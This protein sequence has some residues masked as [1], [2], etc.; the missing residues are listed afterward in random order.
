M[1][2]PRVRAHL[3]S[4][5]RQDRR[6]AL[7]TPVLYRATRCMALRMYEKA[8]TSNPDGLTMARLCGETVRTL[9][10]LGMTKAVRDMT[11]GSWPFNTTTFRRR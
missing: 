10:Q 5:V 8:L 7:G 1:L 4:V 2:D 3:V 6:E 11:P 9:R